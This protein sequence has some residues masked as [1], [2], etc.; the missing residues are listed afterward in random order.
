MLSKQ[1]GGATDTG[2]A[3]RAVVEDVIKNM[4]AKTLFRNNKLGL[5]PDIADIAR[6][7]LE[8]RGNYIMLFYKS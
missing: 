3:L 4:L 5:G 1:Q 2:A 6:S 8:K 7:V